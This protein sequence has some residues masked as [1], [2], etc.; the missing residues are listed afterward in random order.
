MNKHFDDLVIIVVA[1]KAMHM[2]EQRRRNLF[3]LGRLLNSQDTYGEQVDV[4]TPKNQK[5]ETIVKLI[6]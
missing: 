4:L 6:I 5:F 1:Y 2:L 3:K